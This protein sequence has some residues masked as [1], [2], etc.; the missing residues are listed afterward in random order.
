MFRRLLPIALSLAASAG[1]FAACADD[2]ADKGE[3]RTLQIPFTAVLGDQMIAPET[4]YEGV[5]SAQRSMT[6]DDLRFYA[7][8][9]EARNADGEWVPL[10]LTN[11]L[12]Q[13]HALT[14]IDLSALEFESS[15]AGVNNYIQGTVPEGSYNGLRFTLGVPFELNHSDAATA[16]APLNVTGMFWS[17]QGGR[18]FLRLDAR[19][20]G[21]DLDENAPL[22]ISIHLGSTACQGDMTNIESCANENRSVIE[23]DWNP[24][25]AVVLDLDTFFE[26]QDIYA[27]TPDTP[28]LCMSAPNDPE[29]GP[30]FDALGLPFGDATSAGQRAFYVTDQALEAH[31]TGDASNGGE[32]SED[33]DHDRH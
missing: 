21:P 5:G 26:D 17:W 19:P 14:L 12:W 15:T 28:S 2:D 3:D 31:A 10:T 29:C 23:L 18:K 8:N 32:Q 20:C 24:G 16:E 6:L 13:N 4:C 33:P 30:I 9:V 25:E 11:R 7:A 1:A 27:N 22:G